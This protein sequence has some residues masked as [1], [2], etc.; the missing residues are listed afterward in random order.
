MDTE[1]GDGW[2]GGEG[3]LTG[4]RE[5]IETEGMMQGWVARWSREGEVKEIVFAL[6]QI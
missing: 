5:K 1:R 4:R 3:G 2:R 6:K